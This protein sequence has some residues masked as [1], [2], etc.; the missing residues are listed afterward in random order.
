[1]YAVVSVWAAARARPARAGRPLGL[2]RPWRDG[3]GQM[4]V[5]VRSLIR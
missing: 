1:M 2:F 5:A 4:H 3:R